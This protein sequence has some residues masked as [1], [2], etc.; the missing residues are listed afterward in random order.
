[1]KKVLYLFALSALVYGCGGKEISATYTPRVLTETEKFNESNDGPDT[2]LKVV[3]YSGDEKDAKDLVSVKYRDTVVNI[4]LG[5]TDSSATSKFASANFINT[6]KTALLVQ[7]ADQSGKAPYFIIAQ[8][9]GKLDVVSLYRPS[10]GKMD[11]EFTKGAIPVGRNGFLVNNDFFVANVTAKV[12]LLKRQKPEE[13]IQGE[14]I[15][16]SPDRTTL[17]FLT[18]Q[19]STLYQV[20]YVAN[21]SLDLPISKEVTSDVYRYVQKNFT[22]QANAGGIYFFKPDKVVDISAFK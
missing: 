19:T 16:N 15:A 13:R 8:K 6:Q 3:K 7:I 12:Y 9:E 2:A 4:K 5:G 10:N 14:F 11:L 17:A 20:N 18:S 21:Q 22:W 1:M